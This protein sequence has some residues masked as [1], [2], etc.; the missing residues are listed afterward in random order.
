MKII[1]CAKQLH[2]AYARTG[3]DPDRYFFTEKDHL[4]MINPYDEAAFGLALKIKENS[5]SSEIIVLTA[6]PLIAETQLRRMVA[7]GA[8]RLVRIDTGSLPDILSP[9]SKAVMIAKAVKQ[10]GGDLILCGKKSLD[11]QSGQVGAFLAHY[12]GLPYIS[13][14]HRCAID[15]QQQK[16]SVERKGDKAVNE[17]WTCSVPAVFSVEISR[18]NPLVTTLERRIFARSFPIET[19]CIHEETTSELSNVP[20]LFPP[21]PRARPKAVPEHQLPSFERIRQLLAGSQINKGGEMVS[22]SPEIQVQ[23]ILSF[24][25]SRSF[26]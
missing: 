10:I 18:E 2:Q 16:A 1:V 7:L 22:G 19:F 23:K 21:L 24:L 4:S 6:G 17:S 3:T 13:G 26:L 20:R 8:D 9:Q 15:F 11:R 25:K 12:L 5:E 14:I